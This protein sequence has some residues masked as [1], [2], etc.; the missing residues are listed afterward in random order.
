MLDTAAQSTTTRRP[1]PGAIEEVSLPQALLIVERGSSGRVAI[2]VDP[3][4]PAGVVRYAN[5]VGQEVQL[6]FIGGTPYAANPLP[7]P[8][9]VVTS[10][11]F[12]PNA[13]LRAYPFRLED[14]C[15]NV[16]VDDLK[17]ELDID[18]AQAANFVFEQAGA[19]TVAKLVVAIDSG[20]DPVTVEFQ[21]SPGTLS[22]IVEVEGAHPERLPLPSNRP[23]GQV[24][25]DPAPT[26]Q[27]HRVR[28]WDL[29]IP[30]EASERGVFQAGGTQQ[31]E[32]I[33]DP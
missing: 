11:A 22:V 5:D 28:A 14:S 3:V 25:L 26:P 2:F 24:T 23:S 7:L 29:P 19:V 6:N 13:P 4:S 9:G 1:E 30:A 16:L 8:S 27:R 20:G 15:G 10:P 17:L 21:T 33:I 18:G 32:I 12:R 31:A